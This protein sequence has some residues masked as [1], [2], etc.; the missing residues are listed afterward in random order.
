MFE[1]EILTDEFPIYIKHYTVEKIRPLPLYFKTKDKLSGLL[2][3][4]L[5][6]S[7][8]NEDEV[9]GLE[10]QFAYKV[11]VHFYVKL[12]NNY[13]PP[14]PNP[15]SSADNQIS[16]QRFDFFE[17]VRGVGSL[18]SLITSAIN[19][20]LLSG[21][22]VLQEKKYFPI[23]QERLRINEVIGQN[24]YNPVWSQNHVRLC[25]EPDIKAALDNQK[26]YEQVVPDL[27]LSHGEF[28]GFDLIEV[29]ANAALYARLRAIK[30]AGIDA[31]RYITELC[32]RVLES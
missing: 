20:V 15:N 11:V 25:K 32:N 19:S 13:K 22:P 26:P 10:R 27:E 6:A 17:E 29:T 1:N 14:F 12:P 4:E 7:P 31:E 16:E 5:L 18:I 3:P 8:E 21:I 9:N 24:G 23:A 28:C 2:N 30:E